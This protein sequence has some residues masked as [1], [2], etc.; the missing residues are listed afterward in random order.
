VLTKLKQRIQQLMI[1]QARLAYSVGLTPNQVSLIGI[2]AA[3]VSA[4]LYW[5][6]KSDDAFLV[7][8]ALLLLTSGFFD[9]LDG[10]LARTYGQVTL[11]GGFLDSLLDR[12]ADALVLTGIILG[13]L[14]TDS[15]LWLLAGL[16]A[17]VGSLLVSYSR[18]KAEA[19]GI[20]METVGLAERAERII[21]LVLASFLT[22]LWR[23][24]LRWSV[25]LLAVLTN[26][27]ALQRTVYFRKAA[28]KKEASATPIV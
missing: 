16:A 4:Y 2:L 19:A 14:T 27:T 17:L 9:A 5:N 15:P 24:A 11:F 28:Q 20:K 21:I 25:S 3:I 22:P 7:A 26:L 18:A 1:G 12:Y 13:W 8:A 10:V 6:S 23:D